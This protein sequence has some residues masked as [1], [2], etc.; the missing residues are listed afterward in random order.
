MCPYCHIF[1]DEALSPI[2]DQVKE[3]VDVQ[4]YPAGNLAVQEMAKV[5]E[6][7]HFWHP[8][9]AG[10]QYLFQ[11]QHG[12]AECLGNHIHMCVNEMFPD[13]AL[14]LVFCMVSPSYVNSSIE[15]SSYACMQS[16]QIDVNQVKNCV[17]SPGANL[18]MLD[19]MKASDHLTET[20][21]YV[22]WI[23]INGVHSESADEANLLEPLCKSLQQAGQQMAGC[24]GELSASPVQLVKQA[25]V[26][27][28]PGRCY[29][30]GYEKE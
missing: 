19:L 28:K 6:G 7:Y 26:G 12:E 10:N 4:L 23:V 8:V 9:V 25:T 21:E 5:S 22:P 11:C 15:L 2:W 27:P 24:T 16:L 3:L 13:K 20:R 30:E 29:A 17:E 14:D 1:F 18:K